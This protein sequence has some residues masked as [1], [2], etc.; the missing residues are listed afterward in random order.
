MSGFAS[1]ARFHCSWKLYPFVH[2][3]GAGS[4][5]PLWNAR[6]QLPF[7]PYMT[8]SPNRHVGCCATDTFITLFATFSPGNTRCGRVK[9]IHGHP[10]LFARSFGH[11]DLTTVKNAFVS[12]SQ[13]SSFPTI[14]GRPSSAN[15]VSLAKPGL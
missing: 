7:S 14:T 1:C 8:E 10:P 13:S 3:P 9:S 5:A 15:H 2:A 11:C 6:P 4:F 12:A